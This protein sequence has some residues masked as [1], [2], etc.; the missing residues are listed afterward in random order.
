ME[1][2]DG[3]RGP[4]RELLRPVF[5]PLGREADSSVGTSPREPVSAAAAPLGHAGFILKVA[6]SEGA[7]GIVRT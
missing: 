1:L 3:R 2:R 5:P 7:G 4:Y 6:V